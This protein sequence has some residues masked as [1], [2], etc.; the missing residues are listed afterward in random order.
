MVLLLFKSPQEVEQSLI[1]SI[2]QRRKLRHR[3]L[4]ALPRISQHM[5][6]E[7]RTEAKSKAR[8]SQSQSFAHLLQT[9]SSI[10]SLAA[11]SP[12]RGRL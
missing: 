5:G 6:R 12:R 10:A 7:P 9:P 8:P 4:K 2:L 1:S 3:K 11:I